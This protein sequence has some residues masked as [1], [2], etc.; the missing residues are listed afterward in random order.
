MVP[1]PELAVA[2]VQLSATWVSPLAADNPTGAA[3][4]P[5]GVALTPSEAGPAPLSL[6]ARTWKLYSIP[7]ARTASGSSRSAVTTCETVPESLE[8]MST[9]S[10]MPSTWTEPASASKEPLPLA[11]WSSLYAPTSVRAP[12]RASSSTAT[13]HPNL[14]LVAPSGAVSLRVSKVLA[15]PRSGRVK[16]YAEPESRPLSSSCHDPTTTVSPSTDTDTPKLS[17]AAA[18][19]AVS[20]DFSPHTPDSLVKT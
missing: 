1:V 13:D 4:R 9:Q 12:R 5:S 8:P 7:L 3:G 6:I 15:Q 10:G 19:E 20:L 17:P 14:S 2:A 18:S 16:T 11:S